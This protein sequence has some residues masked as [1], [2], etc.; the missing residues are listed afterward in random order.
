MKTILASREPSVTQTIS[1][2]RPR[3]GRIGRKYFM[4]IFE[5]LR[6]FQTQCIPLS[7]KCDG[8]FDCTD[9]SD[10]KFC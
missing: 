8:E 7:Q 9:G 1:S 2:V 10:E 6:I 5:Y 3:S 4:K